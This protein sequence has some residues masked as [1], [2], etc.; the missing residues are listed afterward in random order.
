MVVRESTEGSFAEVNFGKA[1]LG[2]KRRT[3]RLV[4]VVDR[5]VR[6][7]GGTL[8]QKMKEPSVLKATYRLMEADQV[9]HA[10]IL[11]PHREHTRERIEAHPGPLLV[12]HDGTELDYTTRS[13]LEHL[14]QIGNSSRRGYVCHNSLVVDP[15]SREV[16]GLANQVLHRRAKVPKGETKA[17]SR[18]REDRESRLWLEGVQGLP[19]DWKLV[20]VC[21]QGAD[22]T[23]FLEYECRSGR[24]FVLRC[25]H[26]RVIYAGHGA[27][28]ER[29]RL[30]SYVRKLPAQG[31]R[32]V[33]ISCEE[34]VGKRTAHLA[35]TFAPVQIV[36]PKQK[37]GDHG[38]QPLPMWVVRVWEPDPPTGEEP[39]EW[40][41]LTNE[42]VKSLAD[43]KRVVG[44]YERRWVVEEY[45]KAQKTG[46]DI[47]SLQF[48]YEERLQP[49]IA[50]LSVVALTLLNLRATSRRPDAKT[51]PA[52]D[53]VS[54]D[55]IEVLSAWRTGRAKPNWTIHEFFFALARLGG[56]Q[57]RRHDKPPGW[58]VLWRGWMT[59]HAM[60]AGANAI[61]PM[62]CGKT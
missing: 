8:P 1:A 34:G 49:M 3:A 25:R 33:E 16:I 28:D 41:L 11:E 58:L 50:L 22:T 17:Q 42:P 48:C 15:R 5:M 35:I 43:A 12:L 36:P 19:A 26:N 45:H 9:T 59:L 37:R 2:D 30:R 56:H 46:C 31:E 55:Y 47:Q 39:V 10:S 51:R 7:P 18:A 61:R 14:G 54:E 53:V 29:R 38:D 27:V 57:N 13:S 52:T 60:T 62:R 4:E 44:W 6:H 20:D 24:R 21:D 32:V 40:F 23:E